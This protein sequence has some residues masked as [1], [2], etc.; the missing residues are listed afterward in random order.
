MQKRCIPE[1][2]SPNSTI[3]NGIGTTVGSLTIA[4]SNIKLLAQAEEVRIRNQRNVYC[5]LFVFE[6]FYV[7]TYGSAI[8]V[9]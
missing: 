1:S 4:I 6:C 9:L 3:I 8:F 7:G 5:L 2:L